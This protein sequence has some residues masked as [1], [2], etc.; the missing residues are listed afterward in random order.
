VAGV[1]AGEFDH[2]GGW[3]LQPVGQAQHDAD[4]RLVR[5][6]L[7]VGGCLRRRSSVS[8]RLRCWSARAGRAGARL[9]DARAGGA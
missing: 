7:V 1:E 6:M 5:R 8:V 9:R 3:A 4:D 2:A